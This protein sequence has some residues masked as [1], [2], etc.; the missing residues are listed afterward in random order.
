MR[1]L[2]TEAP[3]DSGVKT[4]SCPLEHSMPEGVKFLRCG[5]VCDKKVPAIGEDRKDGAKY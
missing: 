4:I 3:P 5:C 1:L 2:G